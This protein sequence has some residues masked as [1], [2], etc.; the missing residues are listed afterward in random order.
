MAD[1]QPTSPAETPPLAELES[2]PTSMPTGDDFIETYSVP[3]LIST[4]RWANR[5]QVTKKR[6]IITPGQDE[7]LEIP[8]AD[9]I[10]PSVFDDSA[11]IVVE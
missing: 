4:A 3:H 9:L 6:S 11:L 8:P 2:E 10:D 7:E 5:H 1:E